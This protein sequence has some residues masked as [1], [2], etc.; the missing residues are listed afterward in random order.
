MCI[1]VWCVCV[2]VNP[3]DCFKN[4]Q[5]RPIRG[6][7][8]WIHYITCR[9]INEIKYNRMPLCVCVWVGITNLVMVWVV[10][11]FKFPIL[12]NFKWKRQWPI[13]RW[14]LGCLLQIIELSKL[15]IY[16]TMSHSFFN[17]IFIL[18]YDGWVW[19]SMHTKKVNSKWDSSK[20]LYTPLSFYYMNI[21]KRTIAWKWNTQV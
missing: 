16:Y 17:E 13:L 6:I 1:H 12:Y 5:S 11:N 2:Q 15:S 21:V 14:F 20:R 9:T 18:T 7:F 19:P 3:S 10:E 8:T 4:M